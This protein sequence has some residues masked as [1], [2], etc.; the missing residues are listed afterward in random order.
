M[1]YSIYFIFIQE[2]DKRI[3]DTIPPTMP[4]LHGVLDPR[5]YVVVKRIGCGSCGE[6]DD[7]CFICLQH[8]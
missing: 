6:V 3:Q 4:S 7:I 8:L 1:I 5:K 2:V